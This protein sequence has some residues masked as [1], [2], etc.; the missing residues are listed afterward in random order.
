VGHRRKTILKFPFLEKDLQQDESRF[1]AG[2]QTMR[3]DPQG[4]ELSFKDINIILD[5][6]HQGPQ[7][8]S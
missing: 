1:M 7:F 5:Q 3:E 6:R 4:P 8:R 2:L